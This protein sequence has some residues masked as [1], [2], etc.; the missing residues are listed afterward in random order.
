M[1]TI[2]FWIGIARGKIQPTGTGCF[3]TI[4]DALILAVWVAFF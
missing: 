1:F 3:P 4:I 2:I